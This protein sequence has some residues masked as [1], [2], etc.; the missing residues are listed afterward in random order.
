VRRILVAAFLLGFSTLSFRQP[1]VWQ[2]PPGHLTLNVWPGTPPGAVA[3]PKPEIDTTTAKDNLVAGK[4]L[5]RLGNVSTPTLTLYKPQFKN[6]GAAV[7]VFPGGGYHIL[8][9]DLEGT[10]VCEWLNSVGIACVLLKY[11][12]PDSGPYPKS[13]AALQDAQQTGVVDASD[14]RIHRGQQALTSDQFC[15]AFGGSGGMGSDLA[16]FTIQ[17]GR[18]RTHFTISAMISMAAS[19][20]NPRSGLS[21]EGLSMSGNDREL[22]SDYVGSCQTRSCLF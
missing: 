14:P 13:S 16:A 12:V 22:G 15:G 19:F 17:P 21:P 4:P 5:I 1:P 2:A 10:E 8:A 11:R 3:N 9:I 18:S 6:T 7:V 20:S